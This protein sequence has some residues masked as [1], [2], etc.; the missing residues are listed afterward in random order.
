M[1]RVG[2]IFNALGKLWWLFADGESA[3]KGILGRSLAKFGNLDNGQQVICRRE[4]QKREREKKKKKKKWEAK[5]WMIKG[6]W[7]EN[8]FQNLFKGQVQ[9]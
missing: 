8:N 6:K 7:S 3:K 9:G 5:Q 2:P 1:N 4:I